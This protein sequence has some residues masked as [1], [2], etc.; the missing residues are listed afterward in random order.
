M[1]ILR[2]AVIVSRN[3]IHS[4][5]HGT[6]ERGKVGE[7]DGTKERNVEHNPNSEADYQAGLDLRLQLSLE[8]LQRHEG[9]DLRPDHAGCEGGRTNIVVSSHQ[10]TA[11]FFAVKR[12]I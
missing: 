12:K 4:P 11:A 10:H 3:Y 1:R 8:E 2:L 7:V 6:E 5:C 9:K